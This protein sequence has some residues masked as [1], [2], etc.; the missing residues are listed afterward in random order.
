MIARLAWAPDGFG[1]LEFESRAYARARHGSRADAFLAGILPILRAGHARFTSTPRKRFVVP[2]WLSA[3]SLAHIVAVRAGART[4]A[5]AL[6]SGE[7][8]RSSIAMSRTCANGSA[9]DR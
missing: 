5:A 4:M 1:T 6:G 7:P 3:D 2:Y 8:S 9:S